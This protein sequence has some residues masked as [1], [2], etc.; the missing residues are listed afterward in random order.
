MSES[1]VYRASL[2][3]HRAALT[4]LRSVE[5][6]A[7]QQQLAV[8]AAVVDAMG[9]TRAFIA[10]DGAAAIAQTMCVQKA[11]ASLLGMPSAELGDALAGNTI[12]LSSFA[13]NPELSL[14]G[15][16]VPIVVD[17]Q[18]IGALGVGGASVAQDID[19]AQRALASLLE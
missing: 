8:C 2:V 16:G 9:V 6:L 17:D 15:G 1:A 3:S 11:K 10:M 4:L 18:L 5:H 14:M 12:H 19:I 7:S 13:A